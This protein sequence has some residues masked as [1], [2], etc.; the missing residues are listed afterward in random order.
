[1]PF[2]NCPSYQ[3]N[4]RNGPLKYGSIYCGVWTVFS[5]RIAGIGVPL[6]KG[7]S[8]V[9][10]T[11]NLPRPPGSTGTWRPGT[12][13]IWAKKFGSWHSGVCNF[14]FC[15]GS[16]KAISNTIDE[17]TLGLL[18]CRNDGQVIPNY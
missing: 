1:M 5:G 9:T 17:V 14:A 2:R 10:P 6:A 16:V 3:D 13:A 8:D 11:P 18:A 12:D 4:R 15:D 7:P